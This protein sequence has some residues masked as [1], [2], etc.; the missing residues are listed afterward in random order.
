MKSIQQQIEKLRSQIRD[1]N[2]RYYVLDDPLIS[3][4]EYDQLFREL[5]E[6]EAKYPELIMPDSPTQRVGAKPSEAFGTITHRLPMLSLENAMNEEE[7]KAFDAR[8]KKGLGFDESIEYVGEPKLDGL[9]VELVFEAGRFVSGSTRGD[10]VTGE[11][12][13][14]NLRTIPA[15]PL[16]LRTET[17]PPPELLE[18][19]GEVFMTKANFEKLNQQREASLESLFANPRNAAAG[20]LRQLDPEITAQ[21]T[22]SIYCYEVGVVRGHTFSNH[23]E[24]LG[25][26]KGWGLPVNP[27][28]QVLKGIEAALAYYHQL[29]ERRETLPYEIDGVVLKVNSYAQRERL[30]IRSRSPRWA[31]AGKF[32]AQQ[33]TTRVED[34]IVSVGRTGALTPV[35]QLK[36]V[37]VGGVTVTHA[38]LHN[39]DEIDRKDIRVGDTVLIQRA[40]DVIPEVVKVIREKRPSGTVPFKLPE[41]CPVCHHETYRP[42]G[43]VVSR[44]QNLSCPAQIKGRLKHFVSKGA[45]DIDGFGEKLIDQ[46]VEAGHLTTVDGIFRLTFDTLSNLERMGAKSA[47]NLLEAI[48]IAKQTTFARFVYALGIRNVGAHLARVL[49]K[50]FNGNLQAFITANRDFLEALE[51][52]G[53]IVAEAILRFWSDPTNRQVVQS[54]LDLGVTITPAKDSGPKPLEGLTFVF[55]GA[56]EQFTRLEAQEMVQRLGG[57]SANSVSKKTDYVV[58]GPGAGSKLKKTEELGVTILTEDEFLEMVKTG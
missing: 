9:A 47:R 48:E 18:V 55:T 14:Q 37:Q 31:I 24:L 58:A 50:A 57:R 23:L 52:V 8:V 49:E 42:P 56:L 38:T 15:I 34:I 44:C 4:A 21:R 12:I 20:S 5:Q 41:H 26:L 39:Q 2:Y 33:V 46:L 28:I 43:E 16:S 3:D 13:T 40:G 1:H 54:C 22:L 35:A 32:K 17:T 29:G 19:R 11:D 27:E 6:L 7:L 45:L 10:G 36:P 53:P 51:E 30:G 25:T